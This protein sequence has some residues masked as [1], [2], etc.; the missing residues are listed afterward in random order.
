VGRRSAA[1]SL[2]AQSFGP[3]SRP[4]NNVIL[5]VPATDD[6]WVYLLPAPTQAESWPL[7]A[8]SRFRITGD[9]RSI[10]ETRRLHNAIIEYGPAT[11]REGAELKAGYHAAVLDDRPEDTDVFLV[12]TRRPRVPEYVVSRTF[13]FR[14]DLNGQ[15][16]AYD[17]E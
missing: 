16:T 3:V 17:R 9:G 7:G 15:I 1:L 2:A 12:L 4:Y 11:A 8:D 10:Q 5:P 6:W 13:Y 14:I